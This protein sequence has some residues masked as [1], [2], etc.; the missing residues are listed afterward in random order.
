MPARRRQILPP[1]P[2][3]S[4]DACTQTQDIAPV[5]FTGN[6]HHAIAVGRSP[7]EG[8]LRTIA[9]QTSGGMWHL[10]HTRFIKASEHL[11]ST[12]AYANTL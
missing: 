4:S 9:L 5:R 12:M 7:P 8:H 1:S 11:C 10:G 6:S 2:K 3:L